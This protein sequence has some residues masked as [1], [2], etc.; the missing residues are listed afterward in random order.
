MYRGRHY[1]D[2]YFGDQDQDTT[3]DYRLLITF[4]GHYEDGDTKKV[5]NGASLYNSEGYWSLMTSFTGQT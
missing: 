1:G 4:I 2:L 3:V 5:G